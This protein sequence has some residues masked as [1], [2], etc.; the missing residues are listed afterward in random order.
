MFLEIVGT[1]PIASEM[2]KKSLWKKLGEV[3]KLITNC[4]NSYEELAKEKHLILKQ[5]KS[6]CYTDSDE[7]LSKY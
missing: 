3:K 2:V 1:G 7:N 5:V 4:K 6:G